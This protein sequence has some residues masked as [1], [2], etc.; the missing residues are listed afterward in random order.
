MDPSV[1]AVYTAEAHAF[2][3]DGLRVRRQQLNQRLASGTLTAHSALDLLSA[4]QVW[5]LYS[6]WG[7]GGGTATN[8]AE[9]I[10]HYL[11]GPD[12]H[13]LV[14]DAINRTL[15]EPEVPQWDGAHLASAWYGPSGQLAG[16]IPDDDLKNEWTV[17]RLEQEVFRRE[18]E[19]DGGEAMV[20]VGEQG[21]GTRDRDAEIA[22]LLEWE[23]RLPEE[24][25]TLLARIL[26]R[27][28][29]V[30]SQ[31]IGQRLAATIWL[32]FGDV[33]TVPAVVAC[34]PK[35]AEN[36]GNFNSVFDALFRLIDLWSKDP[37]APV[38][39]P[40]FRP[41]D[42]TLPLA[43]QRLRLDAL[44]V[45]E[46]VD[47]PLRVV[48]V[49][50]TSLQQRCVRRVLPRDGTR[51]DLVTSLVD[52]EDQTLCLMALERIQ[53]RMQLAATVN[54]PPVRRVKVQHPVSLVP[55]Y[56][57][58]YGVRAEQ[59]V[60]LEP[61]DNAF[62]AHN[63][64]GSYA[65]QAKSI[66]LTMYC[67]DE[68]E[69]DSD[70][71]KAH[72]ILCDNGAGMH[73]DR[74]MRWATDSGHPAFDIPL[75]SS[76]GADQEKGPNPH[77][78]GT[79]DHEVFEQR[80][81]GKEYQFYDGTP[82]RGVGS[83]A[84][85][86][87]LGT[88]LL[89]ISKM[90]GGM[91]C[92]LRM[93]KEELGR[94]ESA[95]A[96]GR[97]SFHQDKAWYT[98]E[99]FER[100]AGNYDDSFITSPH[101]TKCGS[102]V[103]R[104]MDMEARSDHF[105]VL[106]IS[107][108]IPERAKHL[109]SEADESAFY[110]LCR[111]V[112]QIYFF[113]LDLGDKKYVGGPVEF[114]AEFVR[115]KRGNGKELYRRTCLLHDKDLAFPSQEGE[116]ASKPVAPDM[117]VD[118]Y[119]QLQKWAI[120]CPDGTLEA[121]E[122][123]VALFSSS[124][125]HHYGS[126]I[127]V[128]LWYLP[129]YRIDTLKK[130]DWPLE[131]QLA[132][133]YNGRGMP[134]EFVPSI[135]L[136]LPLLGVKAVHD[137]S[138]YADLQRVRGVIFVGKSPAVHRTKWSLDPP[139][140]QGLE[141]FLQS[142]HREGLTEPG[143]WGR[144]LHWLYRC[145]EA[146]R[147]LDAVTLS[148]PFPEL[149]LKQLEGLLYREMVCGNTTKYTAGMKVVA[150]VKGRL[151]DAPLT[152]VGTI[153]A[154]KPQRAKLGA[155]GLSYEGVHKGEGKEDVAAGGEGLHSEESA[156]ECI[157]YLQR[158]P[159][160]TIASSEGGIRSP[161]LW[162]VSSRDL[163][164][165]EDPEVC[166]VKERANVPTAL[167]PTKGS[168]W[169]GPMLAC[170]QPLGHPDDSS[171]RLTVAS[172]AGP[173]A[174]VKWAMW[175]QNATK[176]CI[177]KVMRRVF[178]QGAATTGDGGAASGERELAFLA[179]S[180]D[181]S[182]DS[183]SDFVFPGFVVHQ[184]GSYRI[185]YSLAEPRIL[186]WE[187][188]P[189][190]VYHAQ[191][192]AVAGPPRSFDLDFP[193][194]LR[195]PA[196]GA[197]AQSR[198]LPGARLNEPFEVVLHFFDTDK[199][200]QDGAKTSRNACTQF[201]PSELH[202]RVSAGGH[203][204]QL[205]VVQAQVVGSESASGKGQPL[206]AMV[207][208]TRA[209]ADRPARVPLKGTE[210]AVTFTLKGP[211]QACPPFQQQLLLL[212]GP[213]APQAPVDA[214]DSD[215]V[216]LEGVKQVVN[217]ETSLYFKVRFHDSEGNETRC[218]PPQSLVRLLVTSPREEPGEPGTELIVL[219]SRS[220]QFRDD[221]TLG[222]I[223]TSTTATA[224]K[225]EIFLDDDGDIA[226]RG[227]KLS[228]DFS[229]RSSRP[230]QAASIWVSLDVPITLGQAGRAGAQQ[231]KDS[232]GQHVDHARI[233]K[234]KTIHVRP[235]GCPSRV[236]L[237]S[238]EGGVWKLMRSTGEAS[239]GIDT[240]IAKYQLP[241][242]M[243]GQSLPRVAL[244]VE[245]EAGERL[246]GPVMEGKVERASKAGQATPS[247]SGWDLQYKIVAAGSTYTS[248][249]AVP[250]DC[251]LPTLT[252]PHR[253]GRHV[254]EVKVK[255][256]PREPPPDGGGSQP[257]AGRPL[258][259]SS[260]EAGLKRKILLVAVVE[261][262][263]HAKWSVIAIPRQAPR[264]EEATL[265]TQQV[266]PGADACPLGGPPRLTLGHPLS[267]SGLALVPLDAFDN[268]VPIQDAPTLRVV[269]RGAGECGPEAVTFLA[270]PLGGMDVDSGP[271]T[272]H[273]DPPGHGG[274]M[275]SDEEA[276]PMD[277]L[278]G[279]YLRQVSGGSGQPSGGYFCFRSDAE[280][281]LYR[282]EPV[283]PSPTSRTG[284]GRTG[285][286]PSADYALEICSAGDSQVMSRVDVEIS[287][288]S[289]VASPVTVR[290]HGMPLK[291]LMC[292]Q[293]MSGIWAEVRVTLP[294]GCSVRLLD[295]SIQ[296]VR[297]E[298]AS[299]GL[300]LVK[301]DCPLFPALSARLERGDARVCG[302]LGAA[303]QQGGT[304]GSVPAST[305]AV[306][307]PGPVYATVAEDGRYVFPPIFA[308]R[309]YNGPSSQGDPDVARVAVIGEMGGNILH[310]SVLE[311][312]WRP[313]PKLVKTVAIS[314][315]G[316]EPSARLAIQ[317]GSPIPRFE[318]AL[319]GE[320]GVSRT[321]TLGDA[322][323][324]R[325]SLTR[326]D[327]SPIR[328]KS[329]AIAALEEL[330]PIVL[331]RHSAK[332][333]TLVPASEGTAPVEQ[334]FFTFGSRARLST[335]TL[336]GGSSVRLRSHTGASSSET[337]YF[338]LPLEVASAGQ[339]SVSAEWIHDAVSDRSA[340][341]A[342]SCCFE[343]FPDRDDIRL[344]APGWKPGLFD[345]MKGSPWNQLFDKLEV[346]CVDSY[347]NIVKE[348]SGTLELS[349]LPRLSVPL[350]AIMP[351]LE[352]ASLAA[353][354]RKFRMDQGSLTV[355]AQ[356]LLEGAG[357]LDG[358]YDLLVAPIE[359]MGGVQ[360]KP[361]RLEFVFIN[362]H[363]RNQR[364]QYL[365]RLVEQQNEI[366]LQSVRDYEAAYRARAQFIEA[367]ARCH[368]ATREAHLLLQTPEPHEPLPPRGIE[369]LA[370][371]H[372]RLKD[373]LDMALN[374]AHREA[375][376][377]EQDLRNRWPIDGLT[378]RQRST[379]ETARINGHVYGT[380][381]M[382]ATISMASDARLIAWLLDDAAFIVVLTPWTQPH[383]RQIFENVQLGVIGIDDVPP[384][385]NERLPHEGLPDAPAIGNPCFGASLVQPDPGMLHNNPDV[386][387]RMGSIIHSLL[388]EAVFLDRAEN[389]ASYA[390]GIIAA[391]RRR[392]SAPVLPKMVS[393]DGRYLRRR[394]GFEMPAASL[395]EEL[396]AN[397]PM[398]RFGGPRVEDCPRLRWLNHHATEIVAAWDLF[399]SSMGEVVE[400]HRQLQP[401]EVREQA[402]D[403]A[404]EALERFN[405]QLR[406]AEAEQREVDAFLHQA[407]RGQVAHGGVEDMDT[408]GEG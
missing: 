234:M 220:A 299:P 95:V 318:I 357:R 351:A 290:V 374:D 110:S 342:S 145:R 184:P 113:F 167:I 309:A 120:K 390:Q 61:I 136:L 9:A 34:F 249:A 20:E 338:T 165:D 139:L 23:E 13:D 117:T 64:I 78:P 169:P 230:D 362:R 279:G 261:P 308:V 285:L 286:L 187:E 408:H 356:K 313:N 185:E 41:I 258:S 99:V 243:A 18:E 354:N 297:L 368:H 367:H 278:P 149:P 388:E 166:L 378:E 386:M 59:L 336:P 88:E 298:A 270:E 138:L 153:V 8:K 223:D 387:H 12:Q 259:G 214:G 264:E 282:Q 175:Q 79:A 157:V 289:A 300:V 40:G 133:L 275:S 347:G 11:S 364:V 69:V 127:K 83:R 50:L 123:S 237:C 255:G 111:H 4:E 100:P 143:V 252:L 72:I 24:R 376:E 124:E 404:Y 207:L 174:P 272:Y 389:A 47:P 135:L 210:Q 182:A 398:V 73:V 151:A 256:W 162:E 93:V 137:P 383:Y 324:L 181:A 190:P 246:V 200:A 160:A 178:F 276:R 325:V 45:E 247:S 341:A 67:P 396:R 206:R 71:R 304:S 293:E 144:L 140:A 402:R 221:G 262:G 208:L 60:L 227:L 287:N 57:S 334:R 36:E 56:P 98:S 322:P 91:V 170:H 25:K 114:T 268:C 5:R 353:D 213:A 176:P 156:L 80:R 53:A 54:R 126:E 218:F 242:I 329:P 244:R 394:C 384:P 76:A 87:Y 106:V 19:E 30:N 103:Q 63:A 46:I 107:S 281:Y 271:Q 370:R 203:E 365:E 406:Q 240:S 407:P 119:S 284:E 212:P 85:G 21:V 66:N 158:E 68:L 385:G 343:V 360:P 2:L 215:F 395:E 183:P 52:T 277:T 248:T 172:A 202:L 312:T 355:P 199:T 112:R 141:H 241:P 142:N 320:D 233:S 197:N 216:G 371:F 152:I 257:M 303:A 323:V 328:F 375:Q 27:V 94:Q 35:G 219:V 37:E 130:V 70:F 283:F 229:Q 301:R 116:G 74:L 292:W 269:P 192:L 77:A 58:R 317:A 44:T 235:S 330:A 366:L 391:L 134:Y 38:P 231:G 224:C 118:R 399:D 28:A 339:Y 131:Q 337:A 6:L 32:A 274:A 51:L 171:T 291:H 326:P 163:R 319:T 122:F 267:T 16:M 316:M 345:N 82:E 321:T 92:E 198:T 115:I 273:S 205:C 280:V 108:L 401:V 42:A 352:F 180:S 344:V 132:V 33:L 48:K 327:G 393:R 159:Q 86:L 294:G 361:L 225:G 65:S 101:L 226:V 209:E 104:I 39:L 90:R 239:P 263:P 331:I 204:D 186:W 201:D 260:R 232:A 340:D 146:E 3:V 346:E 195:L 148:M 168:S 254:I 314:V 81:K 10:D 84:A 359:E 305:P 125:L 43:A 31:Y 373:R 188:L 26:P 228:L 179:M 128:L 97:T 177:P 217:R 102:L 49:D 211:G 7:P 405:A 173:K 193:S 150:R 332:V 245:S 382:F 96:Q 400:A 161:H 62:H 105:T 89:V 333:K 311:F 14:W 251:I 238:L 121:F 155:G 164:E 29:A 349:V 17:Q 222:I 194:L 310:T 358:V 348:Y 307:S 55:E 363:G 266:I 1:A 154:F 403:E 296:H 369:A 302:E 265:A 335:F 75:E 129:S 109:M 306:T 372:G 196:P 191:F 250:N 236:H 189:R 381:P 147:K 288:P 315:A 253:A 392:G 350:P 377:R 379:V 380:L 15:S 397:V 295:R 22:K